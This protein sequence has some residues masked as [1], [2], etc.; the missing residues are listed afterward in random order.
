MRTGAG[1]SGGITTFSIALGG[2]DKK[3][4]KNG[5]NYLEQEFLQMTICLDHDIIDGAPAARFIAYLVNLIESG[6]K[7]VDLI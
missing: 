1:G 3:I 7:L 4:I 6:S 5:N 2:I